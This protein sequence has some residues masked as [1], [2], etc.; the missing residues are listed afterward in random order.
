MKI[1]ILGGSFDPPHLGHWWVVR[2]LLELRE[3]IDQLWLVPAFQHQWKPIIASAEERMQMLAGFQQDKVVLS[4]IE[5]KREGVS[6]TI[7]TIKE[8]KKQTGANLYWV[9]GTDILGEFDRWDRTDELIQYATFLVFPRDPYHLPKT[10]PKGFEAIRE[11]NLITSSLSSTHIRDRR[12]N[13]MTIHGFVPESV[14]KY[15]TDNKLYI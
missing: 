6:Y 9:V 11:K 3:D 1:A 7:D 8:I 4:D 5:M 2:Q 15:I 10:L 12:K 14:E 13:G